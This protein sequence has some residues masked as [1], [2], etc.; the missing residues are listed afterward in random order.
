MYLIGLLSVLS[1][2]ILS[3]VADFVVLT[4]LQKACLL[5]LRQDIKE[6]TNK[7]LKTFKI[8]YRA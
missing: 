3:K 6:P 8:T 7:K 1:D 5:G 2:P 4:A